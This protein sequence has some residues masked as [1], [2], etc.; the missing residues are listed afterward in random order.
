[1]SIL[2]TGKEFNSSPS[3]W[4][5]LVA[6][7]FDDDIG[8][9]SWGPYLADH[10]L[11]VGDISQTLNKGREGLPIGGSRVFD[12]LD[13]NIPLGYQD[14]NTGYDL[15]NGADV[16][17]CGKITRI[18]KEQYTADVCISVQDESDLHP[19]PY[20]VGCPYMVK[21][22]KYRYLKDSIAWNL[23]LAIGKPPWESNN[24]NATWHA[25]YKNGT[26]RFPPWF[27]M[28]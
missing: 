8:D 11:I 15:L 10:Q 12:R 4:K 25:R 21:P 9:S 13:E 14:S 5:L 24:F 6:W 2:I 1:M 18:G 28:K 27:P 7:Y 22:S 20:L 26:G 23:S 19:I 17:M 16:M 3:G